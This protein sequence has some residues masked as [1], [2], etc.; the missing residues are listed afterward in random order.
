MVRYLDHVI[1]R[2][3]DLFAAVCA[4][5]LEGIVAKEKRGRYAPGETMWWKVKHAAYSQAR[6]RWEL[7][8]PR[9]RTSAAGGVKPRVGYAP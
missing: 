4:S 5:D 6:D 7:F 9:V 1:G 3:V 8:Q 2:G